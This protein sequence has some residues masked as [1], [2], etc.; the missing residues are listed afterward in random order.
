[1]IDHP[2]SEAFHRILDHADNATG[3]GAAAALAG[4]MAA[5]VLAMVARLSIDRGLA[6]PN[7]F[8][9]MVAA[10]AEELSR[11]LLA[12]ADAD[13]QAFDAVRVAY[14]LP[15]SNE[16][17]RL[18]R[19]L[20]IQSALAHA[21]R[22]PLTNAERCQRVLQLCHMLRDQCNP[23]VTSDLECAELLARAGQRGCLSNVE[24]N[25]R[26]IKDADTRAELTRRAERLHKS[27]HTLDMSS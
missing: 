1:M 15:R 7:T 25:L 22:V 5:A 2:G 12:G 14:R 18:A 26:S 24:T 9:I 11:Q 17:Q 4:A 3:G 16:T 19:S 8:Y 10:E 13:A 27:I 23:N 21:T 20:A 6:Q